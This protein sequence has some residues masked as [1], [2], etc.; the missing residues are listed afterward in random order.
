MA[1]QATF[2]KMKE[3]EN[4][5]GLSSYMILEMSKSGQLP[6]VTKIGRRHFFEREAFLKSLK[7][8]KST[9]SHIRKLG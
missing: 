7:N 2:I 8:I 4:A 1:E 9:K 5:L 3:A 6:P